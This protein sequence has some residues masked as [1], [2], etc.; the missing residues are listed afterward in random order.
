M[1]RLSIVLAVT[2]LAIVAAAA[3]AV[4]QEYS[5]PQYSSQPSS[6]PQFSDAPGTTGSVGPTNYNNFN[7]GSE[8]KVS[9]YRKIAS[10]AALLRYRVALRLT[11]AQEKYWPAAAAALR[12]LSRQ[13]ELNETVVK[14]YAPAV[15]PLIAS[16]NDQ[17]RQV[18]MGLA[19]QAGLAQYAALF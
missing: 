18:A 9:T 13:N 1:T 15:K 5:N 2:G 6:N 3:P 16:L 12:A 10:E 11:A 8:Q 14:R 4:A 19:A 17:Q 7:D